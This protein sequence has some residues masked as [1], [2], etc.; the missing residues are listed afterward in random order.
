MIERAERQNTQNLIA[1]DDCRGYCID[2]AIAAPATITVQSPRAA[3]RAS[4]ATLTPD[5]A[6]VISALTPSASKIFARRRRTSS[7]SL[8]PER[9]LMITFAELIPDT[10]GLSLQELCGK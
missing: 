7:L 5:S 9:V 3:S 1:P 6:K 2:G 8:I 10:V 4:S